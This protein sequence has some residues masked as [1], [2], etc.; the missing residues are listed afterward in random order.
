MLIFHNFL[1]ATDSNLSKVDYI[2]ALLFTMNNCVYKLVLNSLKFVSHN[3]EA[4]VW[5]S[6]DPF[7][8]PHFPVC[9]MKAK[10]F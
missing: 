10:T 7:V 4:H 1:N 5:S 2:N 9:L 3:L 8:T 6:Q